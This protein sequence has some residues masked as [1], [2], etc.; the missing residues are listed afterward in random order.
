MCNW[1]IFEMLDQ[2]SE[3][4]ISG[5]TGQQAAVW[6]LQASECSATQWRLLCV[7]YCELMCNLQLVDVSFVLY[8]MCHLPQGVVREP[9]R[10]RVL[11]GC[12]AKALIIYFR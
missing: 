8:N 4:A 3:A 10:L 1:H 7:R 2:H 11:N 9:Y 5:V 12:N 6:L